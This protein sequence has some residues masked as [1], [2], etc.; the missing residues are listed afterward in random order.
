MK[1]KYDLRNKR[2]FLIIFILGVLI[3][4]IFSLFI[5]KYLHRSKTVYDVAIGSVL[6]DTNK[7][8]INIEDEASLS[9][10]WNGAYSLNYQNSKVSLGKRVIVYDTTTDKIYLYGK[11]YQISEDGKIRELNDENVI[12]NTANATFYKLADREY[13]LVDKQIY[14]ADKSINASNYLLVELDRM[15]NAKLSNDKLNLKTVAPTKLITSKYVFDIAN[16]KLKFDKLDIDLMKIMGTTNEYKEEEKPEEESTGDTGINTW[17]LNNDVDVNNIGGG[18]I[19][20]TTNQ[21]ETTTLNEIKNKIKSTSII[22]WSQGFTQIDL[23]YVVYDPFDEYQSVYIEI[24]ENLRQITL[25]KSETHATITGLLP[26]HT[27]TFVF[28]YNYILIRFT[29]NRFS[30]IWMYSSF[31]SQSIAL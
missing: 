19:N 18:V 12:E 9:M 23:D 5:Y 10:R 17:T 3:L 1:R 21:G 11:F 22:R 16:E 2:N 20:N 30:I 6:Q 29:F 26:D 28:R 27:Y 4:C 13:L 15:G 31:I 25:N 14:S 24:A 7:N 8:Y